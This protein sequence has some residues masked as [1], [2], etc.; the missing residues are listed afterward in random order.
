MDYRLLGRSGLKVSALSI[1]TATFGGDGLWGATDV[2]DAQRQI[3]LC[4]DHGVNLVDTANVYADSKSESILGEAL[5]DGRR[6]RVLLATKVRFAR[7]PGPNDR[8]LSRWHI[9]RECEN[10]LRRMKTDVIDLYQVHEW[11]G[12]TP[13]EETMEALDTLIKQGKV[14]YVGCSNY[15]AWHLMKALAIADRA[16]WQRFVSQQIHYTLQ[17]REAE[18]EL[19]PLGL[20]QGVSVLIWSPLGGGWLSGK[21]T[22]NSQPESGRQVSGFREPPITDWDKLWDIVD[23]IND[24]AAAH[25]VSGAQV[26]LAWLLQ[27]P[28]VASVIIGGRRIEQF[29]DNLKA[30]H[31]QLTAE[32]VARLD[33]VSQPPL[34]YPYWHQSF[35]ATD[36]LGAADLALHRPYLEG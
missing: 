4:L 22:R 24:V 16:H 20:D 34:I 23:V 28:L 6:D 1:G 29:E 8:G 26:S 15:S 36:R 19:V 27:R 17:A 31:L 18:Y 13:L 10:S 9:I 14:R 21:Y 33:K 30:A 12:E 35:T 3:D 11:D 5:S 25:G 2:S 32:E 7:G